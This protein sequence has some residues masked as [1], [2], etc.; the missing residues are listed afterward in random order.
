MKARGFDIEYIASPGELLDKYGTQEKV[1]VHG[2]KMNRRI[3]I[4]QDIAAVFMLVKTIKKIKPAIVHSHTPKAGLLGMIAA[5]LTHTPVRIYHMRGIVYINAT[6][7]KR[8]IL[9]WAE[10]I[11]CRLAHRVLCNS[12]SLRSFV[13]SDR[14]CN[15]HKIMTLAKGS[16]QGV[17]ASGLFNPEN[18]HI[19]DR[20]RLRSSH[21]IPEEAIV[22]GFVGRITIEKG[23]WELAQA[24]KILKKEFS[25]IYLL[26]AGPFEELDPLP[27]ELKKFIVDDSRI[28][29]LGVRFDMPKVYSMIDIF[30]LPSYREGFSNALLE[31]AAMQLPVVTTDAIGCRDAVESNITGKL[32]PV[33]D[34]KTLAS[35]LREYIQNPELRKQHGEAGRIRIQRDFRPEDIWKALHH[36]YRE[37]LSSRKML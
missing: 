1:P 10:K 24:W 5:F 16:G 20:Q 32:V 9:R 22:I 37:L 8:L 30:V 17:D 34:F 25:N 31:A 29:L 18:I 7:V 12:S 36:E 19:S 26:M 4:L 33:R 28:V 3:R 6:G 27:E 13:I 2:V 14:I 21:S 23:I 15:D 11:S 35:A